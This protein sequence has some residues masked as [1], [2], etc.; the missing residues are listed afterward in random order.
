MS[1]ADVLKGRLNHSWVF[2]V[3]SVKVLGMN[4]GIESPKDLN[5][6][7]LDDSVCTVLSSLLEEER[8][9]SFGDR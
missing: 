6:K 5:S 4:I 8:P 7:V 3:G 2:S 1:I 9:P